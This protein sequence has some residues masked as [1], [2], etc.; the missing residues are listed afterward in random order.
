MGDDSIHS[1]D[2]AAARGPRFRLVEGRQ[3]G[4]LCRIGI[5]GPHARRNCSLACDGRMERDG[6]WFAPAV[7]LFL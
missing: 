1:P 2:Y 4:T 5:S 6:L 3:R 7:S